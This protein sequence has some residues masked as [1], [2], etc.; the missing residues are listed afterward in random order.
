[1]AGRTLTPKDMGG[2]GREPDAEN[3]EFPMFC[4][5]DIQ[6]NTRII[7]LCGVNDWRDN[8]SPQADGWF[9]SDFY[10]FHH[11]LAD[12]DTFRSANQLWL[13]CVDPK[14]LVS[15][16]KEFV[17]GSRSGER[18]V[19]L[20]ETFLDGIE[21]SHNIRVIPAKDL[22]ERFL[23]T[24]RSE[25]QIA[26]REDQP[27]LVF[28]FGH[29]DA[30][31]FGVSVGGED[32]VDQAPRLTRQKF[33]SATRRGVKLTLVM[34]SCYSG[35]WILQ[36][37]GASVLAPAK[38]LNISGMTAVN[39]EE[40]SV[41][42]VCS[43]SCGRA[44]GSIY[45]TSVLNALVNMAKV[46]SQDPTHP[47]LYDDEELSASPT[48]I[49]MCSSVYEAYKNNDPFYGSHGISFSAQDDRWNLEW[50][51]RS[52]FPLLNYQAKWE[53]LREVDVSPSPADETPDLTAA[54]GFA[55][56]IGQ[57]Y[58]NVIQAK[59]AVYMNSF[60]GPDNIGPNVAHWDLKQLLQG[61]Q[62]DKEILMDLNDMLDYRLSTITLASH[63]VSFLDLQ[64]PEGLVFDTETWRNNLALEVAKDDH[65]E[66]AKS[67]LERFTD[68]RRHIMN[69]KVFDKPLG[70]QGFFYTKPPE[71]L[72]IALVDSSLSMDEIRVKID[73]LV[74]L[75][76]GAQ[77]FLTTMPLA[78]AMMETD[79]VIRHRDRFFE[80]VRKFGSRLRSLSPSKR[81]RKPLPS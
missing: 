26:A 74:R 68:I 65:C 81:P 16:Y 69:V 5:P 45:A 23:A 62:Y 9:F 53:E 2:D 64:F 37:V 28:V 43:Q 72:A 78:E 15:K 36:P 32:R 31:T 44:G 33:A 12:G 54:L 17:H 58:H 40:T 56:S 7:A 70:S 75:K 61:K 1:M 24:L 77:Q 34:T 30:G 55:G 22:L 80:S 38:K 46:S 51:K 57:G 25:T 14:I 4:P 18:R 76:N 59:A 19:V 21:A 79:N 42:W 39:A 3:C 27:V 73:S 60:P 10:L 13:T 8:A 29:G 47:V 67:K 41:S 35:G 71:Y 11:L 63:Y 50:R 48:Y 52:G 49:N 6:P 66:D 20:D